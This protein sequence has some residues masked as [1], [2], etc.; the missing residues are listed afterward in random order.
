MVIQLTVMFMLSYLRL[1]G[2]KVDVKL[3]SQSTPL[4]W[5]SRVDRALSQLSDPS[6]Q[7]AEQ[8]FPMRYVGG[9]GVDCVD[10][11]MS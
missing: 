10:A 6:D 7:L 5:T 9:E 1:S 11:V 4:I 8:S 2:W 3:E